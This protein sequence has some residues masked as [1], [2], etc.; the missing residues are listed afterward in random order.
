MESLSGI[1]S[2]D[3]DSADSAFSA[4]VSAGDLLPAVSADT[5][6]I[7]SGA[8]DGL[9]VS[10][11]VTEESEGCTRCSFRTLFINFKESEDCEYPIKKEESTIIK[12]V[13]QTDKPFLKKYIVIIRCNL[14]VNSFQ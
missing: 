13:A 10:A 12:K 4:G 3:D 11:E 5:A 6:F 14:N 1:V 9:M 8:V 2:F 7:V